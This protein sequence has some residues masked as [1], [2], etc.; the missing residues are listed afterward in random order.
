MDKS[1][2]ACTKGHTIIDVCPQV[3]IGKEWPNM[4]SIELS[5][6]LSTFLA[7]IVVPFKNGFS[8]LEIIRS[9]SLWLVSL[10]TILP[11]WVF[12]PTIINWIISKGFHPALFKFRVFIFVLKRLTNLMVSTFTVNC[13]LFPGSGNVSPVAVRATKRS[14]RFDSFTTVNAFI[15]FFRW[16]STLYCLDFLVPTGLISPLGFC[17]AGVAGL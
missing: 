10:S 2:A 5:A 16:L 13:P 4:V 11:C 12:R 15:S 6:S 9:F 17:S 7:S 3:W 14:K 8:P 1:M